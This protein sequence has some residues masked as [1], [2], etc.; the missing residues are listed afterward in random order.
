MRFGGNSST[1]E[2]SHKL[3]TQGFNQSI[4]FLNSVSVEGV[5][6]EGRGDSEDSK[7]HSHQPSQLKHLQVSSVRFL[8]FEEQSQFLVCVC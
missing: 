2:T 8:P 1:P 5:F 4:S 7:P 3:R 6:T